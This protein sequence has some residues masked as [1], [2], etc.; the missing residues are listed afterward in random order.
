MQ[1]QMHYV[2]FDF[3]NLEHPDTGKRMTGLEAGAQFY[4]EFEEATRSL[5]DMVLGSKIVRAYLHD[6]AQFVVAR[7]IV[8]DTVTEDDLFEIIQTEVYNKR[9]L[10][11]SFHMGA[12]IP[13]K[14]ERT[15]DHPDTFVVWARNTTEALELAHAR[16]NAWAINLTPIN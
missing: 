15:I 1:V 9:C 14:V 3:T 7:F 10:S 4:A 11:G 13:F 2:T 12:R 5:P 6:E 16:P 8:M